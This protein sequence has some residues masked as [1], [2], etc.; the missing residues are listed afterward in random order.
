MDAIDRR[1]ASPQRQR[2]RL[3]ASLRSADPGERALR[4]LLPGVVSITRKTDWRVAAAETLLVVGVALA[5]AAWL[6][7]ADPLLT[8]APFPWLWLVVAAMALRYGSLHGVLGMALALCAWLVLDGMGRPLGEF[9]R[10][11]FVGGLALALIAGAFAD[12]WMAQVSQGQAVNAYL[13]ERLHALTH[14]HFLLSVSHD[15]LEQE[16][17]SRPFTL[18]ETLLA[19]RQMLRPSGG[20]P[21]EDELPAAD[22]LLQLLARHCRVEAAALFSVRALQV[23]QRPAARIGG[24]GGG[25]GGDAAEES[26]SGELR[27]E[28][29]AAAQAALLDS[30]DPM[31]LAAL[32]S[33]QLTHLQSEPFID[34]QRPSRYLVCAPVQASDGVL[35]GVL[36][37]ERIAFTSLTL[38][39]LQF[40]TVLLAYYGDSLDP[41]GRTAPLLAAYPQCPPEF[42]L[43]LARA[44]RLSDEAFLR[45][46]LVAYRLPGVAQAAEQAVAALL[47]LGRSVDVAWP[48]NTSRG[49]VLLLL[50]PLT[51][52]G[53]Q[54][55]YLARVQEQ[56]RA[57]QGRALEDSGVRVHAAELTAAPLAGQ[58]QALLEQALA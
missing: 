38:E 9:P 2:R 58:V 48:M 29:G 54:A 7:P 21:R 4:R 19:M 35:H 34:A 27:G 32:Q 40:I 18:R 30:A 14:H 36:V 52:A 43:E 46:A 5:L 39:N 26:G 23:E 10:T 20:A 37:V 24:F 57:R 53:G 50:L 15:R 1:P 56:W 12:R 8:A 13:D 47:A 16:L 45:S 44:Q 22:W 41:S 42:A 51:D 6:R 31:L 17:M 49:R 11:S 33:R 28:F 55:G 25:V 3:L